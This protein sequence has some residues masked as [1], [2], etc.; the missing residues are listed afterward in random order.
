MASVTPERYHFRD[1]AKMAIKQGDIPE[2]LILEP[3]RTTVLIQQVVVVT[4]LNGITCRICIAALLDEFTYI[5]GSIRLGLPSAPVANA[6][7]KDVGNAFYGVIDFLAVGG[8][9][10]VSVVRLVRGH[11]ILSPDD[12]VLDIPFIVVLDVGRTSAG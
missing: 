6:S 8:Y 7:A 2:Y 12:E 1:G 11:H 9:I 3:F 4:I 5:L 10:Y